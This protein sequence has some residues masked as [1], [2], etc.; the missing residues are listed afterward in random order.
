[1]NGSPC[2]NECQ[3]RPSK[4]KL[5][6]YLEVNRFN[7]LNAVLKEALQGKSLDRIECFDIS[8]HGEATI[9][10]CVVADQGGTTQTTIANMPFMASRGD[11]YAAMKQVLNRRY[12]KQP[13]PDLLLIDGGKGQ[14]WQRRTE[15]AGDF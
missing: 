15:R 6:D 13:L 3:Q 9:A 8:H 10:S 12:S 2:P 5:G 1:M 7:A 11:D 4:T 14:I